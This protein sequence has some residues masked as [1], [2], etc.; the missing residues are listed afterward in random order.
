[1]FRFQ[2]KMLKQAQKQAQEKGKVLIG[3][4]LWLLHFFFLCQGRFHGEIR[5]PAFELVSALVLASPV[6]F[7]KTINCKKTLIG[8]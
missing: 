6:K 8:S 4:R 3:L 1:M 5:N 7:F 2:E